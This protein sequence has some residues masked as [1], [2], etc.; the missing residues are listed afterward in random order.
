MRHRHIREH[1]RKELPELRRK[2]Q[3]AESHEER[4]AACDEMAA[5]RAL[6]GNFGITPAEFD[7]L[8]RG[9]PDIPALRR[10]LSEVEAK[11][12]SSHYR[13]TT[14]AQATS[15]EAHLY[16]LARRRDQIL[17]LLGGAA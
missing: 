1:L 9:E 5:V 15:R 8:A 10:E 16:H 14:R 2:I 13:A 11:L 12:E 7:R 6:M 3:S 17:D 4:A